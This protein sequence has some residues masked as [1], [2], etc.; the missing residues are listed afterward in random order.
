MKHKHIF[1]SFFYIQWNASCEGW[2]N[3]WIFI[4]SS[5]SLKFD[6]IPHSHPI[7]DTD[8]SSCLHEILKIIHIEKTLKQD[9]W[10]NAIFKPYVNI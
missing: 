6:I 2:L 10:L 8:K 9:A 1:I 5:C 3:R 7:Y 4:I